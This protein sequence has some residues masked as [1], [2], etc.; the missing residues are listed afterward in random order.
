[1]SD[2][3][4]YNS[5]G[6]D[7]DKLQNSEEVQGKEDYE[8]NFTMESK[9]EEHLTNN[10]STE[11]T[12]DQNSTTNTG[13]TNESSSYDVNQKNQYNQGDFNQNTNYQSSQYQQ[14]GYQG[15]DYQRNDNQGYGYQP[16][17]ANGPKRGKGGKVAAIAT[18]VIVTVCVIGGGAYSGLRYLNNKY[19]NSN[20]VAVSGTEASESETKETTTLSKGNSTQNVSTTG[21]VKAQ[22]LDVSN[23]VEAVMPSVVAITNTVEVS[24]SNP[25]YGQQT[26]EGTS[27][28][29]GVIIGENDTELLIVTN[30]H[31]VNANSEETYQYSTSS[32]GISVTFYGDTEVGAY[33]K[34]TDDDADL[35]VIAVKLENI[36]EETMNNI[37]I[38]TVG[39]SDEC[40]VGNGVIAIGNALGYGQSTTVGYISALNRQVT[41][42]DGVSKTLL[43]TDAAINPGNSGGGLFNTEGQLIGIN[44]AKYSST[45]VEGIGYAIP[46]SSA[47]S[48]I[49]ELM[50]T[51]PRIAVDEAERGYLGIK[52]SDVPSEYVSSFGY[53]AGVVIGQITSGSKAEGSGLQIYDIITAV[54]GEDISSMSA[55]KEELTYYKAGE[56][57]ELTI[58]RANG[59]TF[60]EKKINVT[61]SAESDLVGSSQESNSKTEI[62]GVN[63]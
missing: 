34:G 23:V 49:N 32:K 27:S 42:D 12:S 61:L 41:T 4:K 37:R 29:S 1:M 14:G 62:P 57:V 11:D 58:M 13:Y 54:N 15:N 36:D 38:A 59:N 40:K 9:E 18:A 30:A 19:P 31:V 45:D 22:L 43:Q 3:L 55:L 10:S 6:N 2:E 24:T 60:E 48:I 5:D 51:E 8:V 35:A 16:P 33:V 53:P 21:E 56:T 50:N 7:M 17:H 46:I 20:Q 63:P 47:E 28:G 44:A 52:G 26:Q 25:F 39:N